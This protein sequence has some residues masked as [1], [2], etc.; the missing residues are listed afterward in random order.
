MPITDKSNLYAPYDVVTD[1][2]L[3]GKNYQLI[4]AALSD[5]DNIILIKQAPPINAE[6]PITATDWWMWLLKLA[7]DEPLRTFSSDLFHLPTFKEH[8]KKE[9]K[10]SEDALA[11]VIHP[12]DD[13]SISYKNLEMVG[14][15]CA[16]FLVKNG[17]DLLDDPRLGLPPLVTYRQKYPNFTGYI[18]TK[19]FR[20]K[21]GKS[22]HSPNI[23]HY[24]RTMAQLE[25]VDEMDFEFSNKANLTPQEASFLAALPKIK[26]L[27][28]GGLERKFTVN[29]ALVERMLSEAS[30]EAKLQAS[31]ER[32]QRRLLKHAASQLAQEL[33]APVRASAAKQFDLKKKLLG[34]VVEHISK[35][36]VK[37][38]L[39]KV[40][41]AVFNPEVE[42]EKR[43]PLTL[44][45]AEAPLQVSYKKLKKV[46]KKPT[47]PRVPKSKT[48]TSTRRAAPK[49]IP[50]KPK[51][52]EEEPE[53]E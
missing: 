35:E 17:L 15:L 39:D 2:N 26:E 51:V 7:E 23:A 47:I 34:E 36:V 52:I 6:Q 49:Y 40:K 16:L 30:E 25:V 5:L 19:D 22:Y 29:T 37:D 45:V 14:S 44:T 32:Q 10:E 1:P 50:P 27:L 13:N 41:K 46:K 21:A 42:L 9:I 8:F 20:L 33:N 11:L 28:K 12:T 38:R 3:L 18:V 4:K 53:Y 31:E 43:D 24:R 48:L